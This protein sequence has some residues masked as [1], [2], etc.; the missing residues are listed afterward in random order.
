VIVSPPLETFNRQ[1]VEALADRRQPTLTEDAQLRQSARDIRGELRFCGNQ[2]T[3]S[4]EFRSLTAKDAK[5][6]KKIDPISKYILF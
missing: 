3:K 2:P 6:A 4:D 1:S 5:S